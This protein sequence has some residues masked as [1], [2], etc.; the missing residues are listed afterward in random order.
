MARIT[1][2]VTDQ[3]YKGIKEAAS[4]E[5]LTP[6]QYSKRSTFINFKTAPETKN[7]KEMYAEEA[8]ISSA[9]DIS[10]YL[11][12]IQYADKEHFVCLTMDSQNN[13]IRKHIIGIG[14]ANRCLVHQRD[15]FRAA[16]TDNSVGIIIAHNHPGGSLTAS[17]Q[18][19]ELEKVMKECSLL[20]G[21][22]LLDSIIVS[23][24][25][26]SSA[27]SEGRI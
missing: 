7:N 15:I 4:N 18:D 14:T 26:F 20:M 21:I 9:Y 6:G 24:K 2:S 23:K 22:K 13:I 11:S 1:F 16:I 12:D 10:K 19:I 25:G 8:G 5:G 27:A 17:T 3:E